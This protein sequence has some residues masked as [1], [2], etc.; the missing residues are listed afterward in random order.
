MD[1][2][3]IR[4]FADLVSSLH[5]EDYHRAKSLVSFVLAKKIE[6]KLAEKKRQIIRDKFKKATERPEYIN[7]RK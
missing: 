3:L 4:V 6:E 1:K 2:E 7:P 5:A